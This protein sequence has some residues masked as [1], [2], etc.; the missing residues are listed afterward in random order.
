M[1]P[2]LAVVFVLG[3]AIVAVPLSVAANLWARART[4]SRLPSSAALVTIGLGVVSGLSNGVLVYRVVAQDGTGVSG[5]SIVVA[6]WATMA[7]SVLW[8]ALR[9]R[10]VRLYQPMAATVPSTRAPFATERAAVAPMGPVSRRA[11]AARD[12]PCAA[13]LRDTPMPPTLRDIVQGDA[14]AM[15]VFSAAARHVPGQIHGQPAMP[16]ATQVAGQPLAEDAGVP[17]DAR[18][19]PGGAGAR[20]PV[21][22]MA[23][24]VRLSRLSDDVAPGARS[25]RQD[26]H[27]GAFAPIG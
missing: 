10:R 7:M 2:D 5:L 4:H 20:F 9:T 27:L 8:V 24:T 16:S 25:H 19:V 3:A 26:E 17:P 13:P 18:G 11:D 15:P 12:R 6:L 1:L 23:E 22:T 21:R 14:R